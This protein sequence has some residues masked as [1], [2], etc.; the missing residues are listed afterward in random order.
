M[1]CPRRHARDAGE[2]A[3]R[4]FASHPSDC[5]ARADHL[6]GSFC[7]ACRAAFGRDGI[8]STPVRYLPVRL[9]PACMTFFGR[10][11]GDNLAAMNT[12]ARAHIDQIIGLRMAS[13]SCS[14]TITVFPRSR[15]SL[16]GFQQPGIVALMQADG[17]LIQHIENPGQA[18]PDLRGQ[19]DALALAAR[20]GAGSRD[21][22]RYSSPTSFRNP[23]RSL[24][25]LQNTLGDLVLLSVGACR[26]SREPGSG[27]A[28]D[29]S[30]PG[31]DMLAVDLH[32]RASRLQ[33]RAV[34]GLQQG[35]LD[36]CRCS[37]RAQ[38]LSV[39]RQR[40]SMFDHSLRTACWSVG[41][42]PVVIGHRD[43]RS[44]PVPN[45]T[46]LR[47]FSGSSDQASVVTLKWRPRPRA[48]AR[49]R[50]R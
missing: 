24:I 3:Q 1:T 16:E 2:G 20:Q 21:R 25:S 18:G 45:S 23:S 17:W 31:A 47:T 43:G 46:V 27:W 9:L 32:A 36:T 40:R 8:C 34:A 39:S 33:P 7:R 28:I 42:Q 35:D 30:V 38:A 37:S 15:R 41:A 4:N 6:D 5:C 10:D 11:H 14:T 26:R 49:S 12:G 19:T 13:S 22:V 44:S 48:S 29:I 50:A